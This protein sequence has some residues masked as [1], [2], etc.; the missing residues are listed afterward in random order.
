HTRPLCPVTAGFFWLVPLLC[1]RYSTPAGVLNALPLLFPL[2][3]LNG[4][5]WVTT[6]PVKA[7]AGNT[8][9]ALLLLPM[10]F[11]AFAP[12]ICARMTSVPDTAL[13]EPAAAGCATDLL[14]LP[15]AARPAVRA[16]TPAVHKMR[17]IVFSLAMA[18]PR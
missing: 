5:T 7:A 12:V 13:T 11:A 8:S 6:G 14:V 1:V 10:S 9:G 2:P 4:L 15:H 17:F 16:R 18:G 3:S